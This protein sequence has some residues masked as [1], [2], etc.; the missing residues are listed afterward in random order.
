LR[1]TI[2]QC[3]QWLSLLTLVSLAGCGGCQPD[4]GENLTREEL[5]KRARERSESLVMN[6]LLSLPTDS[7][8]K[9]LTAK[10]GHWIETRQQ[11]KSNREDLQ[12]LAV[13]SVSHGAELAKIPGT[14]MINEFTR[15]TSLPKGQ[16]KNVE[17][18]YFVPFSGQ[19]EDPF[20]LSVGPSRKL[21]FR[22][23]LLNWPL[24]TPIL[25]TPNV[26]PV[27]ELK[28][29]EFQLAVLSPQTLGYDVSQFA[30]CCLLARR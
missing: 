18:Q 5:E 11:F 1:F 13:G 24:L 2:Y 19:Q 10:A 23:D 28:E 3:C 17:L 6:E 26:K 21:N 14:D 12:V 9:L 4:S 25:P 30:R 7:E 27:N 8:T 16:T 29:H 20:D 15:R 22:T